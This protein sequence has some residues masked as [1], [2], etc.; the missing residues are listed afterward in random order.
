[1]PESQRTRIRRRILGQPKPEPRARRFPWSRLYGVLV[2]FFAIWSGL[3]LLA[4]C[5]GVVS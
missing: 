3:Q 5:G 1:M 2:T 4:P